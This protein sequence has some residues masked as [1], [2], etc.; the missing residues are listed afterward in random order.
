M[1]RELVNSLTKHL[2]IRNGIYYYRIDK[3]QPNGKYKAFRK[4]LGTADLSEA[5]QQVQ[6]LEGRINQLSLPNAN[7]DNF[8][9]KVC[10]NG[11]VMLAT[12]TGKYRPVWGGVVFLYLKN[13]MVFYE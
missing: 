8:I 13:L 12:S 11:Y 5:L 9:G 4:S 1:R 10:P 3:R 6:L 7:Y 2:V